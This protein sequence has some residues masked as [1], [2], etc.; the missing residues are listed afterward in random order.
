MSKLNLDISMAKMILASMR[1][2]DWPTQFR[3]PA[4]N[5]RKFRA[6]GPAKD[7]DAKRS[8]L[9]SLTSPSL[10]SSNAILGRTEAGGYSLNDSLI[11]MF[12][13]TNWCWTCWIKAPDTGLDPLKAAVKH[14]RRRNGAR[15]VG[16][17]RGRWIPCGR[18]LT[19]RPEPPCQGCFR[20]GTEAS[21]K[22]MHAQV[23]SKG[24]RTTAAAMAGGV[25]AAAIDTE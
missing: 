16:R 19:W 15:G 18:R 20:G 11:T 7:F 12:N 22:N 25:A 9:N 21:F 23:I 1:A 5:G 13:C 3:G 14:K 6:A 17:R 2:K 4:A 8:G 10:K 24:I